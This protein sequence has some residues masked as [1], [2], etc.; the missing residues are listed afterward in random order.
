MAEHFAS[1]WL[2]LREPV[3]HR[4]RAE[5]LLEPFLAWWTVEAARRG[6]PVL[7]VVDLG[8]GTG[9]NLRYLAPRLPGPQSWTLVDHDA[10]LLERVD[11]PQV[12]DLVVSRVQRDLTD[13]GVSPLASASSDEAPAGLVT[14]SALFDLASERWLRQLVEAVVHEGA[15][16]LFT[17]SYDGNIS[18]G[19][20]DPDDEVVRLA[21][22]EHQ[23]GEKGFGA[24]LGPT[25]ADAIEVAFQREGYRTLRALSPWNIGPEDA[26]LAGQL[27]AGWCT[28]AAEQRPDVEAAIRSWK[29]RRLAA[30]VA[31]ASRLSVGHV[32][33]LAL[34]SG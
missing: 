3:D 13:G 6:N 32:D 21:V 34:P 9:S 5:E 18:W 25:A 7:S 23:R 24:A 20:A 22:N 11:I 30:I 16:A 8:C 10:A 19:E 2:S 26:E 14:A 28:A 31:G 17:L 1:D 12:A 33:V 29:E 4:A 27:V 15:A